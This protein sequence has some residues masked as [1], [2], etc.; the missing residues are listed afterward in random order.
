MARTY[1]NYKNVRNILM[2]MLGECDS[3]KLSFDTQYKV[4]EETPALRVAC[5]LVRA[6]AHDAVRLDTILRREGGANFKYKALMIPGPDAETVRVFTNLP[7]DKWDSENELKVCSPYMYGPVVLKTLAETIMADLG[8]ARKSKA[9]EGTRRCISRLK[10]SEVMPVARAL[11]RYTNIQEEMGWRDDQI[12]NLADM[13]VEQRKPMELLYADEPHQFVD[14]YSSGPE[15]CM[16]AIPDK[17]FSFLYEDHDSHPTAFF[18]FHPYTR[19]VYVKKRT[20]DGVKVV[21]RC[22][23]YQQED[24]KWYY[25][26]IYTTGSQTIYDKFVNN[27]NDAGIKELRTAFRRDVTFTIPGYRMD[28]DVEDED[29]YEIGAAGDYAMPVPYFDNLSGRIRA[30]WDKKAKTFTVEIAGNRNI[31]SN[32][33]MTSTAGFT[34]SRR[35][36]VEECACCGNRIRHG[37]DRYVHQSNGNVYCS[38]T[39]VRNS[40]YIYAL[41]SDGRGI[42]CDRT[43]AAIEDMLERNTWYT[44]REAAER[45]GAVAA[46]SGVFIRSEEDGVSRHG[47]RTYMMDGSVVRVPYDVIS[48]LVVHYYARSSGQMTTDHRLLRDME[49]NVQ[50][51]S[52]FTFNSEDPVVED[53]KQMAI[54][55][56]FLNVPS[57]TETFAIDTQGCVDEWGSSEDDFT[58]FT[59]SITLLRDA[60]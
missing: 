6:V 8:D 29:D 9:W 16:S 60:A 53:A 57:I 54:P 15:S 44:N 20:R 31:E 52:A 10:R 4:F 22:I 34:T 1:V 55:A 46:S 48:Q 27:L 13:V 30:T 5:R 51:V 11:T 28:N 7:V 43:D 58:F 50:T 26:R 35:I 37:D 56:K 17:P 38:T 12:R 33:D 19:G 24:G 23:I 32:V 25:G 42:V 21:A 3:S 40:G 41:R 47:Y 36:S 49:F 18:A 14:M 59:Q 45:L 39:C 2:N